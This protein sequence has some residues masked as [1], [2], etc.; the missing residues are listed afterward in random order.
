MHWVICAM[1]SNGDVERR[2]CVNMGRIVEY[3]RME[4][5]VTFT[6]QCEILESLQERDARHRSRGV[7]E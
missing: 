1:D 7:V 5:S 3:K 2:V 4:D 6:A